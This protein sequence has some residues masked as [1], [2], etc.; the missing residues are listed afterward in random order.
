MKTIFIALLLISNVCFADTAVVHRIAALNGYAPSKR[1]KLAISNAAAAYNVPVTKMTAIAIAET[2]LGRFTITRKNKNGTY[3]K[4]LFQINTINKQYCLE[5]DLYTDEGSAMCAAKLLSKLRKSRPND[6]YAAYHSKT[7]QHKTVYK[8]K[9]ENI[10]KR[11]N[12]NLTS[13]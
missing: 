6:Y 2:G 12:I 1:I 7:P 9:I 8:I 13:K 3:D 4:G 11:A 5:Y 10:L